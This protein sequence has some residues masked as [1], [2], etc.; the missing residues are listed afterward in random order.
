MCTYLRTLTAIED[1]GDLAVSGGSVQYEA[2]VRGSVAVYT[3]DTGYIL[4]EGEGV[5][6]CQGT[7]TQ[8][9]GEWSGE[10]PSCRRE[11]TYIPQYVYFIAITFATVEYTFPLF[12]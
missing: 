2:T 12:S 1:C 10:P 9:V 11:S 3:C 5:R 4:E 8:C 7:G 6:T